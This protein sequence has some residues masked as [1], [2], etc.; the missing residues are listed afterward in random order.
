[1]PSLI[2]DWVH[3]HCDILYQYSAPFTTWGTCLLQP[4]C[5][6]QP[7]FIFSPSSTFS[8]SSD[9]LWLQ[10]REPLV[11]VDSVILHSDRH[12]TAF[13]ADC[14][15]VGWSRVEECHDTSPEVCVLPSCSPETTSWCPILPSVTNIETT[16]FCAQH[17]VPSWT[18]CSRS[19]ASRTQLPTMSHTVFTVLTSYIKLNRFFFFFVWYCKSWWVNKSNAKA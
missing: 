13:T 15:F 9:L 6:L 2:S 11:R 19:T 5:V 4:C 16:P 10:V 12:M 7:T 17:V 1:M 18:P 14:C 3:F 8:S